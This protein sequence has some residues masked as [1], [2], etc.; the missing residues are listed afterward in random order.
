MSGSP[1][2]KQR[3]LDVM[4]ALPSDATIEDAIERLVFLAKVE[5]GL[6]QVAVG[7]GIPHD[8]IVKRFSQ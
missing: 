5:R 1:Q 6:A 3:V 2:L 8:E 7:R 4:D